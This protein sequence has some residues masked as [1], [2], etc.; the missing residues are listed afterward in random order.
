MGLG[1]VLETLGSEQHE[2]NDHRRCSE[3]SP[4]CDCHVLNTIGNTLPQAFQ[5]PADKVDNVSHFFSFP[6]TEP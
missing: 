4:L 1:G 6:F 3:N 2:S 5:H